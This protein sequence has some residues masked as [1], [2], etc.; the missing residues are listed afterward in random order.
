MRSATLTSA[1]CISKPRLPFEIYTFQEI[2]LTDDFRKKSSKKHPSLFLEMG[3]SVSGA[4][5]QS[6][7][8]GVLALSPAFNLGLNSNRGLSFDLSLTLKLNLFFHPPQFDLHH[9]RA[10]HA[11]ELHHIRPAPFHRETAAELQH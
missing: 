2:M 11:F 5:R 1:Y 6:L 10:V 8:L 3:F 4:M 7:G 9:I